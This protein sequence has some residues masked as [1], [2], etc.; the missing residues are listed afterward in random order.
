[1]LRQIEQTYHGQFLPEDVESKLGNKVVQ[2]IPA[3]N[4]A[5]H[6]KGHLPLRLPPL[7]Q[8]FIA[9]QLAVPSLQLRKTIRSF[10]VRVNIERSST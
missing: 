8:H 10:T 2:E 6:V 7:G 9:L 4:V 1:M 5:V 3:T